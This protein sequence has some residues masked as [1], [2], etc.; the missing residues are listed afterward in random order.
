MRSQG[1]YQR[2]RRIPWLFTD[3]SPT[4]VLPEA[5]RVVEIPIVHNVNFNKSFVLLYSR[6]M[7]RFVKR[8]EIIQREEAAQAKRLVRRGKAY[9]LPDPVRRYGF[10]DAVQRG[11]SSTSAAKSSSKTSSTAKV[12]TS[13][14]KT[15]S[16]TS[17]KSSSLSSSSSR[18]IS[19]TRLTDSGPATTSTQG[20]FHAVATNIAYDSMVHFFFSKLTTVSG[21]RR[22]GKSTTNNERGL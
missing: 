7:E 8:N 18:S 9:G 12:T 13:A 21:F 3:D 19:S 5:K 6:A 14:T 11:T 15:T 1:Q 10:G 2:H 4:A 22:D 20:V 17:V 16:S